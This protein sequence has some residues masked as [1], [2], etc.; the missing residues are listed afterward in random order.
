MSF[1]QH[2]HVRR[3]VRDVRVG[4]ANRAWLVTNLGES[5]GAIE[6]GR[7]NPKKPKGSRHSAFQAVLPHKPELDRS[8]RRRENVH[9]VHVV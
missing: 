5:G 9:I 7:T 3:A 4:R 1:R 6:G 8:T 2:A